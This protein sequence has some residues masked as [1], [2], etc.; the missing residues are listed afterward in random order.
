MVRWFV[1]SK[2]FG[3]TYLRIFNS[4][5]L[6][7]KIYSTHNNKPWITTGIKTSCQHNRELY[8]IS[9]DNNNPKLK[10]H[11]KSYF[12]ILSKV[13]KAAKQFYYN[14]RVSKSNNKMKTT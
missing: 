4:S 5:F 13:I 7:Q 10:A 6:L 11:Y 8:L 1:N 9:R 14:N 12:L 2:Y 3:V